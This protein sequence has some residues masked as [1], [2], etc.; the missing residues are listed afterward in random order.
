MARVAVNVGTFG[1]VSPGYGPGR[2][3]SRTAGGRLDDFGLW[4]SAAP[5][6]RAMAVPYLGIKSLR[7]EYCAVSNYSGVSAIQPE[8]KPVLADNFR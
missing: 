7:G 1:L 8:F 2:A 5:D 4:A 6:P 3:M